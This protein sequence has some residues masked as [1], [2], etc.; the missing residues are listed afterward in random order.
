[1][2][3]LVHEQV[4]VADTIHVVLKARLEMDVGTFHVVSKAQLE[5]L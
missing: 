5:L 4:R 1:M 3:D 2:W